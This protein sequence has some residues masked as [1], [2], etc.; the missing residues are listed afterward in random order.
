LKVLH[1]IQKSQLRGAEI[2][3]SQLSTHINK[4]GNSAIIASIFNGNSRLPFKGKLISLHG[5]QNSRLHDF[6]AWKKLARLIKEE[7][8][9]VVQANAG[10]TLKYA[11]LSKLF[12]RWHQ[13]IVFRNASTI[14]LYIKSLPQKVWNNFLF[15]FTDIIISVSNTSAFDF[16]R[17]FPKHKHKV[18]TIP[19]GIEHTVLLKEP[20]G[21]IKRPSVNNAKM[22]RIVHVG[23]FTFE[24]NHIGLIEIFE[25]VLKKEPYAELYLVGDGPLKNHTE[26]LVRTKGL[27]TKIKFLGF[28]ENPMKHIQS[29]DVLVLPSI[30]EG[31]PGVILEAFFCKIPVVAFDVGG[32]K[33]ILKNNETG[34][35]IT[36]GDNTAFAN[37][38]IEAYQDHPGN[39]SL[40]ENAYKLVVSDYLN[41]NIAKRFITAYETLVK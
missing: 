28:Q 41:M 36:Q 17:L 2:F 23:G 34:R 7:K 13:P 9:D 35:L 11:V 29:S 40:I 24:K 21:Q 25:L 37:A 31:L 16:S 22:L 18:I 5:N 12:F 39:F 19:I 14:S 20:N 15:R 10:D 38:I 26:E 3:A 4:S 30:I 27:G 1:L 6:R 33:E 8:P 32:I